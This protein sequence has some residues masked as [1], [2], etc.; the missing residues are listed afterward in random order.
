[1]A[2]DD[3][4]GQRP[5]QHAIVLENRQLNMQAWALGFGLYARLSPS[6]SRDGVA[7][8]GLGEREA[9]GAAGGLLVQ[10]EVV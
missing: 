7:A 10:Q 6:C 3:L 9:D 2:C 1:M 4:R 5:R 8:A